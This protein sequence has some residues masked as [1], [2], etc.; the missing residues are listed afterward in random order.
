VQLVLDLFAPVPRAEREGL[1]GRVRERVDVPLAVGYA[2]FDCET[3]GTDVA[4]DE[5]VSLALIRLDPDGREES[6]YTVLVRP[7]RPIPAEATAVHGIS[8]A[9]VAGAPVFAQIA[10]ELRARL[11][12]AAFVAHNASFD[13][14]MLQHAF[15][16]EATEYRPGAIACTLEAFRLLEP[17]ADNHRLQTIC[18]R[19]GVVLADAH[20]AMSDV[21]ATVA[22]LRVLLGEGIA[23]ETV[24]LDHS[25]YMRLRSR[26]DTRPAS[27]PQ[28]RRVFGL[29]RSAG[30]T[31]PDG[32][33]DRE[34]IAALVLRATGVA[35]I[36]ALTRA[37]VQDVYDE[38]E[39]LIEQQAVLAPAVSA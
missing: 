30:L 29:A 12:D 33:A 4:E 24:E 38:L 3:T 2:V 6:R 13:L 26:G 39:T 19:R 28:V 36:D 20:D 34:Q 1:P 14:G 18:D 31:L 15:A 16:R 11:G 32:T 23:P 5:I 8:D 22:L 27:E 10:A 7:S 25:A 9:D 37:Q 17:L 35:D 21:C